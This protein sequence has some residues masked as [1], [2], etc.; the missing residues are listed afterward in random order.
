MDRSNNLR[1]GNDMHL[2]ECLV[3]SMSSGWQW[4]PRYYSTGNHSA[5]DYA[6][7]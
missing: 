2:L 7:C 1:L 3:L 5:R 4:Q 6:T